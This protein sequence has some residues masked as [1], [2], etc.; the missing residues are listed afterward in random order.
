MKLPPYADKLQAVLEV[1]DGRSRIAMMAGRHVTGREGFLHG[2]AISGLLEIAAFVS[3]REAL[4][5][6]GPVRIKPINV[7]V[8]FRRGG[9]LVRT[10]A[11]GEVVR[12]GTRIANVEATAWQSEIDRPIAVARMHFLLNRD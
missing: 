11:R 4:V 5:T 3:L 8:D 10:F 9:R 7:T 2:G 12:L 1:E 6:V